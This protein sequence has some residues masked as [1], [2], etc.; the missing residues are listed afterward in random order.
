MV[1][2]RGLFAVIRAEMIGTTVAFLHDASVGVSSIMR[3]VM[4][5][6]ALLVCL[7]AVAGAQSANTSVLGFGG[8][9]F[10]TS[11]ALEGTSTAP[12]LGGLVSAGLTPNVQVIGEIGRM[13]DI[14]PALY[15]LLDLTPVDLRISAWYGE[16]GVRFITSPRS[17]V[18][19]YAQATAG[20]ARLSPGFS[21]LGGN[22]DALI[23][24]G[25][26]FLRRTEP[27][28]G[29][30]AGV[31]LEHGPLSVDAGYRF[32]KITATGVASV[33]NAGNAYQV[34]E[35]RIGLGVRF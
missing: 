32:T 23:G 15:D 17:A 4:I 34:N 11:S 33:I 14:R 7:P 1:T 12:T 2:K 9:T 16:G 24:T 30:G 10:S 18:R 26:A 21:G 8:L 27:L 6:L 28:L 35:A 5:L 13:S 25:L 3:R 31:L 22:P 20:F 19:P 29:V